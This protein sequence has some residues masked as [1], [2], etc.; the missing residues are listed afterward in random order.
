[1]LKSWPHVCKKR[2]QCQLDAEQLAAT[3]Q[4]PYRRL[5]RRTIEYNTLWL[6]M[7]RRVIGLGTVRIT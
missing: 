4:G 3:A 2:E 7:A 6:V 5:L 1:M